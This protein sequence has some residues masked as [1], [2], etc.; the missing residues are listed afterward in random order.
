MKING[1]KPPQHQMYLL[2]GLTDMQIQEVK[3]E[4][5]VATKCKEETL[6]VAM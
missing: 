1:L 3:T 5:K 6:A 4:V 2:W